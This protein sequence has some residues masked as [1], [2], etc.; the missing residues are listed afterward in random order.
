MVASLAAK[1]IFATISEKCA[2]ACCECILQVL[3]ASLSE[4]EEK[5]EELKVEKTLYLSPLQ[6]EECFSIFTK[7]AYQL[8]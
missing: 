2:S 4:L 8:R 5:V 3:Y 7:F 6:L 1:K